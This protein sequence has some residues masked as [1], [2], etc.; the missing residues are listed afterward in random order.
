MFF[1][2]SKTLGVLTTPSKLIAILAL[3]GTIL[4][5][6]R[7]RRCGRILLIAS[8][9]LVVLLGLLPTGTALLL[10][11]EQRFPPWAGS[12]SCRPASSYSAAPSTRTARRRVTGFP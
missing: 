9:V 7:W 10:V 8:V 6:M 2:L 1:I 11:L 12:G 3:A 5:L 4:M